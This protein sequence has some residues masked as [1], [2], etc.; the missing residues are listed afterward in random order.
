MLFRSRGELGGGRLDRPR[1]GGD[2]VD[3]EAGEIRE[4]GGRIH[5]LAT[6]GTKG[7]DG[8]GHEKHEKHKKETDW[9][10]H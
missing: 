8:Y 6:E 10:N 5:D 2:R 7:A 4:W 9:V 3:A 1:L